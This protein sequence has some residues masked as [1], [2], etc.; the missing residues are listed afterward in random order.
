MPLDSKVKRTYKK[1]VGIDETPVILNVEECS[2]GPVVQLG[3]H[4]GI[5]TKIE[6]TIKDGSIIYEKVD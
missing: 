2:L 5:F 4:R 6:V 1:N 3:L